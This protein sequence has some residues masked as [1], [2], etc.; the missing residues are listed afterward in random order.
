MPPE[1]SLN[2]SCLRRLKFF[3]S[4]II[5][6]VVPQGGREGSDEGMEGREGEKE[7]MKG[8]GRDS[9]TTFFYLLGV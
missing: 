5:K 1:V 6:T 8:E 7:E 4:Q 3:I 9:I 2:Q